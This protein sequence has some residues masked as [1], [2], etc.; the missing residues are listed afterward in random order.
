VRECRFEVERLP[1]F[2][3]HRYLKRRGRFRFIAI[4]SLCR[5][6]MHGPFGDAGLSLE[7]GVTRYYEARYQEG[8]RD[9]S[10]GWGFE[11]VDGGVDRF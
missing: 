2:L 10:S 8:W 4:A 1:S 3:F 11:A 6:E 7:N 5:A 9:A